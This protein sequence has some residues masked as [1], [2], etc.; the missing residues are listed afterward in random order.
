MEGVASA[1]SYEGGSSVQHDLVSCAGVM[2]MMR[3]V[4]YAV[5]SGGCGR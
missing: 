3:L 1:I 5:T 2:M 4:V